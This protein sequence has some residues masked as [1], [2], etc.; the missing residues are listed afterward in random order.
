MRKRLNWLIT[1]LLT[2]VLCLNVLTSLAFAEE[3]GAIAAIET[4]ETA[5]GADASSKPE[6]IPAEIEGADEAVVPAPETGDEGASSEADVSPA[7]TDIPAEGEEP[8][9]EVVPDEDAPGE[10]AAPD[11]DEASPDAKEPAADAPSDSI[12]IPDETEEA[13]AADDLIA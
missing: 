3:A 5:T 10:E 4:E 12:E 2:A 8:D 6:T 11:I 13:D 9:E 7:P 1:A